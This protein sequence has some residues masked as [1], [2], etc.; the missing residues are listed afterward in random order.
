[1]T[2]TGTGNHFCLQSV[3]NQQLCLFEEPLIT[4]QDVND[5]K[6][7]LEGV[8]VK[9]HC[10]NALDEILERIPFFITLN[11]NVWK[12]VYAGDRNALRK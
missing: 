3:L 10:K 9:V 2:R 8:P 1:M 12:Y 5:W 11:H 4:P 7:L 6:I